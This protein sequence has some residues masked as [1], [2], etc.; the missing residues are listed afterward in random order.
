MT[1]ESTMVK[2]EEE[3]KDPILEESVDDMADNEDQL[4]L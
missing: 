4:T 3:E 1:V 2:E